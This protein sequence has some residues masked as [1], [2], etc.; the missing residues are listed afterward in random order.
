MPVTRRG[1]GSTG[2]P[3]PPAICHP[4]RELQQDLLALSYHLHLRGNSDNILN[5]KGNRWDHFSLWSPRCTKPCCRQQRRTRL[6]KS[7]FWKFRKTLPLPK[8]LHF[9]GDSNHKGEPS[10]QS[11]SPSAAPTHSWGS[12]DT[13]SVKCKHVCCQDMLYIY[14]VQTASSWNAV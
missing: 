1:A 12:T 13:N 5:P 10:V 8:L 11:L 3:A 4:D 2:S 6:K 7:Y 9:V 14:T